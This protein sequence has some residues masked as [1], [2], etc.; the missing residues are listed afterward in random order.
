MRGGF[1][2]NW[3]NFIRASGAKKNPLMFG[4]GADV[5]LP[6]PQRKIWNDLPEL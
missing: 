4:A 5:A 6:P 2:E 3:Q 1:P